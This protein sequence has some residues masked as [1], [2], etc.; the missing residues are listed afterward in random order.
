V[1]EAEAVTGLQFCVY[2]GPAQDDS[3]ALAH[4]LFTTAEGEPSVL[5]VV[6]TDVRRVEILTAPLVRERI[7]DDECAEAIAR[8]RPGLQDGR[9]DDALVAAVH[10]LAAVAGPGG[11]I[12]AG[13]LPDLFDET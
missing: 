12:S 13:E 1:H 3:Q 4:R 2:L 5:V 7:P 6:A 9:F 11:P 8:M 10:H